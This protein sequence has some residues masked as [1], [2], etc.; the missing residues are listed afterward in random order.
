MMPTSNTVYAQNI[1]VNGTKGDKGDR[2]PQGPPGIKGDKGAV[3][4]AGPQGSPG[5]N[6]INGKQGLPGLM[7]PVG[8]IGPQGM[9]GIQGPPG[10]T[11][12]MTIRYA[13]SPPT[14]IKGIVNS[15]A[16]CNSD[17][18]IIGGGFSIKGGIGLILASEPQNNSWVAQ[19]ANP[20]DINANIMGN[21]TAHATCIK[22]VSIDMTK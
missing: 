11:K 20:I 19:A 2:G 18:K 1:F 5:I 17:E 15:T 13:D 10:T 7:G 8:P 22:V 3:G 14:E 21:L 16:Q 6:G 4:P 12:N 9:Q